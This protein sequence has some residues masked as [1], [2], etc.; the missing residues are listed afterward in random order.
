MFRLSSLSLQSYLNQLRNL[1][2]DP[3]H[4]SRDASNRAALFNS[5]VAATVTPSQESYDAWFQ[6]VY[7]VD[8]TS[9]GAISATPSNQ[10]LDD[11]KAI[12]NADEYDDKFQSG[13]ATFW[14]NEFSK[15]E[16]QKRGFD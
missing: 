2:R 1:R 10:Q 7:G 3:L 5:T 16:L 8:V 13:E 4:E 6:S 14:S 11:S 9:D 15:I 12:Q